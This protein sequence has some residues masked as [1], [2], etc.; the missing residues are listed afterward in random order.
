[1]LTGVL[2]YLD[3][4]SDEAGQ[5]SLADACAGAAEYGRLPPRVASGR[6]P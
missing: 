5:A 6:R 2:A 1:V 4:P 3:A